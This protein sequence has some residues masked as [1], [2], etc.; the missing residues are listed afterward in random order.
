MICPKCGYT[1]G[2]HVQTKKSDKEFYLEF[3]GYTLGT[4][5]AEQAWKE[6]QEM[7][8]REAP[9]VMSDIE[10]YVSQVDGTWIKSRSHHRSHLKQHKMIELGNDV[11]TQHKPAEVSK[12]SQEA[13]KRQIA[14]LA[15]AKLR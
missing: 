11:I 5:E 9:M 4:S 3:W 2:N 6:K 13:R 7:V 15:Y 14:E 8:A 1:E 12:K 10:G